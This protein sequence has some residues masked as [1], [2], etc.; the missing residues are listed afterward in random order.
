[1]R[2]DERQRTFREAHKPD[3]P[4]FIGIWLRHGDAAC[5]AAG[6]ITDSLRQLAGDAL[7]EFWPV[8]EAE[9]KLKELQ[10]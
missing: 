7:A 10:R 3:A 5:L 2:D 4:P 1:M 6:L 8:A 9:E